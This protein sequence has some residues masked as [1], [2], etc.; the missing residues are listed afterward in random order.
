MKV[1]SYLPYIVPPGKPPAAEH[2]AADILG[3]EGIPTS[4]GKAD[5]L[6]VSAVSTMGLSQWK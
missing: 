1:G 5:L 3:N 4:R 2:R 6:S